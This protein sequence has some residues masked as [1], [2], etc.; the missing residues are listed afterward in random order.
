MCAGAGKGEIDSCA[1]DSGGPLACKDEGG[2]WYV[3]G[4]T[5]WGV[6]CAR[7]GLYGVYADVRAMRS[8]IDQV[9]FK[10]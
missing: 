3:V 6:G 1:G 2:V 4:V 5:S 10:K 8:W 9:V 7:K